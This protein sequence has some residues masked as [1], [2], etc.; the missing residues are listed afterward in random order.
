MCSAMIRVY[1]SH[2]LAFAGNGKTSLAAA[3]AARLRRPIAVLSLQ[4]AKEQ[5]QRTYINDVLR[6]NNGNRT[7]TATDLDVDP[8][9]IFR[10]LEKERTDDDDV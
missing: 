5:F 6:L 7:K 8:R 2:L 4:D 10:H 9:T 3:L 1:R